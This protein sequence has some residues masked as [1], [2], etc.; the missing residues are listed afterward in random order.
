M[1]E[2]LYKKVGPFVSHAIKPGL[3]SHTSREI[4][5]SLHLAKH[6]I[7]MWI[8][9]LFMIGSFC[10]ASASFLSFGFLYN[11]PEIDI[12]I[13][14]FIGSI[15]FTIAAY[16]QYLESINFDI[17]HLPHVYNKHTV[18]FWWRW[19]PKNMGYISS[20]TQFIGTILFNI[21]TFVAIFSNLSIKIDNL[22]VWLPNLLGS[23]LFLISSFFAYLE[24]Y[25][26]KKIKNFRNLTW[27]IIWIN[28][29]GSVFFQ[30]SALYSVY[31]VDIDQIN[32]FIATLT[33][34]LGAICFFV[35]ALLLR[36]EKMSVSYSK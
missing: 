29:F 9:I 3:S 4:R 33:T 8:S 27:V 21:S 30:I 1:S 13:F 14:Y 18:W 24:V 20:L 26:D 12:N 25:N 11:L 6:I 17:T 2:I 15:F 32:I 28:I 10:F 23:I 35:A 19:R 16:L 34:F 5:K 31:T 36:Y 7:S 22:F